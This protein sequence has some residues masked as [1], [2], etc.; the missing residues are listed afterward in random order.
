MGFVL[1][2]VKGWLSHTNQRPLTLSIAITAERQIEATQCGLMEFIWSC[3]HRWQHLQLDLDSAEAVCL[4]LDHRPMPCL[5]TLVYA[6]WATWSSSPIISPESAPVLRDFRSAE[7]TRDPH[8]LVL[9]WKNLTRLRSAYGGTVDEALQLL[10]VAQN[11]ESCSLA[12]GETGGL[13][14]NAGA[15]KDVHLASLKALELRSTSMEQ[16]GLVLDHL[17]LPELRT[18]RLYGEVDAWH[19]RP[20]T[21]SWPKEAV[22]RLAERQAAIPGGRMKLAKLALKGAFA[23]RFHEDDV[24]EVTTCMPSLEVIDTRDAM[25][26]M[27]SREYMYFPEVQQDVENWHGVLVRL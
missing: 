10:R 4:T 14:P 3:S 1:E 2:A 25:T 13:I 6:Q 26:G 23:F 17:F 9:P 20:S 21:W 11:L 24:R 8:E 27:K 7:R 18:L 12:I 16:I 15:T 22:C 19:Y 5:Q